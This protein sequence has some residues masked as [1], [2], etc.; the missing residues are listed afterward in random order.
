MHLLVCDC[1]SNAKSLFKVINCAKVQA[2]LIFNDTSCQE[3]M[4]IKISGLLADMVH[5]VLWVV[6]VV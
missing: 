2:L 5:I 3:R 4:T 1:S 6:H